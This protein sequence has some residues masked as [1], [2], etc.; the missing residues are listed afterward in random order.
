VV[1]DDRLTVGQF[2]QRWSTQSLPGQQTPTRPLRKV[3]A[4]TDHDWI[5]GADQRLCVCCSGGESGR[6]RMGEAAHY[7]SPS[8]RQRSPDMPERP[9][10]MWTSTVLQAV[11]APDSLNAV[12][13][14]NQPQF[15][16]FPVISVS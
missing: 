10:S 13:G 16:V 5:G 15:D 8:S 11:T 4:T 6:R 2:L 7:L 14:G 3:S 9:L 12:V 1:A